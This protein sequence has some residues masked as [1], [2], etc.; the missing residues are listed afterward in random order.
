MKR[1]FILPMVFSIGIVYLRAVASAQ[2]AGDAQP[3]GRGNDVEGKSS[4]FRGTP[5]SSGPNAVTEDTFFKSRMDW[6]TLIL[7]DPYGKTENPDP[8]VA[9]FLRDA[10]IRACDVAKGKQLFE[11]QEE[12]ARLESAGASGPYF[13]F[14][15]AN[16]QSFRANSSRYLSRALDGFSKNP[17]SSYLLY[18]IS[19]NTGRVLHLAS[20][21][22]SATDEYSINFRDQATLGY[23]RDMLNEYP[24]NKGEDSVL[25]WRLNSFTVNDTFS[26]CAGDF[27]KI[28]G[29]SAKVPRWIVEFWQG[30]QYLVAAENVLK[31]DPAAEAKPQQSQDIAANL[32]S[33]REHFVKSWELNPKDPS[34][35]AEMIRVAMWENEKTDAIRKWFDRAVAAQMDF[36]PA[37]WYM[38]EGFGPKRLGSNEQMIRFGEECAR[39]ARYNTIVPFQYVSAV[40]NIAMDANDNGKLFADPKINSNLKVILDTYLLASGRCP[41]HEGFVYLQ[42]LAAIVAYKGGRLDEAGKHIEAMH[43][44]MGWWRGKFYKYENIPAME[45]KIR[46]YRPQGPG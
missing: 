13:Y 44:L 12:E 4:H 9:A 14:A 28:I 3:S 36:E 16:V 5:I 18:M 31:P 15:A 17:P 7:L 8:N 22:D 38:L 27:N 6:W 2:G 19:E 30:K 37:Y 41:M 25:M 43:Q 10:I 39:T 20:R 24:F 11:L 26:R 35:A 23:L 34:A 21:Y 45:Q 33:A 46:D 42:S 29:E 32:A 40:K 1:N